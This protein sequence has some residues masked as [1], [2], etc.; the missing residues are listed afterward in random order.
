MARDSNDTS[1]V[2]AGLW[3]AAWHYRRR[4]LAALLLLVLAKVAAVMVPLVLKAIVDRFS[5]PA[6]VRAP[7]SESSPTALLVLPVFLLLGYALLRFSGT[8][9]TEL[10]DLVFA[11]VT[12]RTVTRFAGRTFAHLLTL[13]PRFHVQRNTGSLIR[14]V[15]RG[16]AGI[17]FL[18]G[19]GL[20]T[21]VPTLVEFTAVLVVMAAGYSLWFTLLI[22][23]TFFVYAGYT[24]SLTQR[25]AV[26]QRRVNEMDSK[27]SGRMV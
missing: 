2:F 4:T 1:S 15:E 20:F 5:D 14:D 19:A 18:L 21:V 9:F 27:A 7:G 8:L 13:S 26:R 12:Q 6:S 3:S 24:M 23:I 11:R 22:I 25:R 16:T 17:G 10:R